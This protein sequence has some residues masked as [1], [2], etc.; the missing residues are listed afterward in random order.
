M[1]KTI[2]NIIILVLILSLS[3][4][5]ILFYIFRR[6]DQVINQYDHLINTQMQN[7]QHM[8]KISENMY[9]M[10]NTML[11]HLMEEK[12]DLDQP[13]G[14]SYKILI[15]QI[16]LETTDEIN[17]FARLQDDPED[18][19]RVHQ[20][21]NHF[22]T[23]VS[24]CQVVFF[25]DEKEKNDIGKY[26]VQNVMKEHLE[27]ASRVLQ[28]MD[29]EIFVE[30]REAS[31]EVERSN[32]EIKVARNISFFLL[33]FIIAICLALVAKNGFRIVS[34]QDE[35]EKKHQA[36]VMHMQ[37]QVI[38]G[39]ANLIESRDGTTGQ[40]VKRTSRYVKMITEKLREMGY[41]REEIDDLFLENIYKAAPLHDIGK[42]R[43]SDTILLKPGKLTPEEYDQMKRHTTEGVLVFD[44]TIGAMED[45]KYVELVHDVVGGHHEKWDG[46][47]YPEGK[48]G[49]EIPL[50]ARIMAVADV[51]DALVSKRCYKEAFSVE[52]AYDI[53]QK[54]SGKHFDPKL[55]EAFVALRP[56]VEDYL[57][58]HRE[59]E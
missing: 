33:I 8:T 14:D 44:Q 36:H 17:K 57:K 38:Y 42:I 47:G 48:K 30:T 18:K 39:M 43:V 7:R 1:R 55:V 12:K 13:G 52:E 32:K 4:L 10:Q 56:E 6:Y 31:M 3:S 25:L 5:A 11:N 24:Q 29:K 40:H 26:Y 21:G 46:S 50:A 37:N 53:I 2:K 16:E 34:A 20:L 23:M 49:E 35:E 59:E 45:K 28:D 22:Q 58:R 51:F 54:D 9:R 15:E 19:E 41:Y 27:K